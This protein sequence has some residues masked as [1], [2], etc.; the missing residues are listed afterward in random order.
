M[1][2]NNFSASSANETCIVEFKSTAPYIE[3]IGNGK[4]AM[5]GTERIVDEAFMYMPNRIA[6]EL[7][8]SLLYIAN[9]QDK[10][11][12][13]TWKLPDEKQELWEAMVAAL[14]DHPEAINHPNQQ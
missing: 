4:S 8:I 14:E 9:S 13:M 1:F 5:F 7:A 2:V 3:N 12:G 10:S 6:K 11:L